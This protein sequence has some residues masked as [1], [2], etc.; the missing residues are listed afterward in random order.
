MTWGRVC[1]SGHAN[2]VGE[3]NCHV[4][5][6]RLEGEPVDLSE[7]D[8]SGEDESVVPGCAHPPDQDCVFCEKSRYASTPIDPSIE[9]APT[10]LG[11]TPVEIE[12]RFS[13]GA[14]LDLGSG[15][16]LGRAAGRV[17]PEIRDETKDLLGVSRIH[18]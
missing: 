4:C 10:A 15:L 9:Q 6:E 14:S 11:E 13:S 3:D 17:V 8:D 12:L 16:L 1:T 7:L 2:G 18:A 5:F